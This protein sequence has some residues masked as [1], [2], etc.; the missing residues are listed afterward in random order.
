MASKLSGISREAFTLV[1]R[2]VV[3]LIIA[4]ILPVLLMS[5]FGAANI[6]MSLNE[7]L[8]LQAKGPSSAPQATSTAN[9]IRFF[10]FGL[11]GLF[12]YCWMVAKVSKLCLTGET[13]TII[14]SGG[15]LRAGFWLLLY[16]FAA[17]L[18]LLI[19]IFVVMIL[20]SIFDLSFIAGAV[21]G[22][23]A[24]RIILTLVAVLLAALCFG[25]AQCRFI[26]G[27]PPLALGDKPGLFDGWTLSKGCSLGLFGRVLAALA[28]LAVGTIVVLEALGRL[29][30][31]LLSGEAL[32]PASG[33]GGASAALLFMVLVPQLLTL[34]LSVPVYW[35]LIVLFCVAYQRLSAAQ[36]L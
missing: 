29:L 24:G 15:T 26:V 2:N 16:Y 31:M 23:G 36:S 21:S 1:R 22:L 35:Y 33:D 34:V 5:V 12:L 18:V 9:L 14:G 20:A 13:A 17:A 4:T 7:V 28:I 25:W 11:A 27:F 8:A 6:V 3:P 19:P 30:P 32:S 10:A